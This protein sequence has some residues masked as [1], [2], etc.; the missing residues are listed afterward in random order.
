MIPFSVLKNIAENFDK[1]G[2]AFFEG[3]R[4]L[5]KVFE[6]ENKKINVKSFKT[7]NLFK[8]IIYKYFRESKAKRSFSNGNYL[9][10]QGFLTPI[11]YNYIE[12]FDFLGLTNSFYFC[13]HLENCFPLENAITNTDFPNR[14]QILKEYTTFLF[15]LHEKKIEFIDNSTGNTLIVNI[16]GKYQFY[17]V[18]LNR[19]NYNKSLSIDNRMKNFGRLTL[20]STVWEIIADQYARL[21][22]EYTSDELY[23]KLKHYTFKFY[24]RKAIKRNLKKFNFFDLKN[25][26]A[27][28]K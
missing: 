6:Y 28:N 4:N 20:D 22:N 24:Y 17:L 7:P 12:F 26:D 10:N 9:I 2:T 19:L 8:K 13:E 25:L 16:N 5:I 21:N 23:N 3:N 1:K 15:N 18:D 27:L 14:I 11:P